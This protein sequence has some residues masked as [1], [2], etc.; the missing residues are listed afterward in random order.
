[1]DTLTATERSE[2]RS[3]VRSIGTKPE[4]AVRRL[5]YNLGFRYRLHLKLPGTPDLTFK[6][7]KKLCLCMDASGTVILVAS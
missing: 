3:R 5:I 2:R 6:P 1:M 4:M 7:R